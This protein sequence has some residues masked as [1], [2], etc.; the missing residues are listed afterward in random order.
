MTKRRVPVQR[1]VAQSLENRFVRQRGEGLLSR[2]TQLPRRAREHPN[3]RFVRIVT[4]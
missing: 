1:F 2:M 3:V 4:S